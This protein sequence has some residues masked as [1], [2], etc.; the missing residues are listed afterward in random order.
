VPGLLQ[1]LLCWVCCLVP[2]LLWLLQGLLLLLLQGLP[3]LPLLLLPCC[4]RA[5]WG[6]TCP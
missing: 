4:W 6:Q 5:S 3:L 1:E 2:A